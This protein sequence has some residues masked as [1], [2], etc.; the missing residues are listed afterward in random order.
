MAGITALL[1]VVEVF[2]LKTI[3]CQ[4]KFPER[5]GPPFYCVDDMNIR[6]PSAVV[7]SLLPT[8]SYIQNGKIRVLVNK[9]A[10]MGVDVLKYDAPF[11]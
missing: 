2:R 8:Q 3:S 5:K 7:K 11:W 4:P 1:K 10:K 9:C 6:I